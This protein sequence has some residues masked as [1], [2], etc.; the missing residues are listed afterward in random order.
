MGGC[1]FQI[2]QNAKASKSPSEG[3]EGWPL[4]RKGHYLNPSFQNLIDY[5]LK[6]WSCFNSLSNAFSIQRECISIGWIYANISCVV[7][8]TPCLQ[9]R[10]R[11]LNVSKRLE[12]P[13]F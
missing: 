3:Q 1:D 9:E 10:A 4:R 7:I 6:T 8:G 12:P 11:P 2:F 13:N 5:P